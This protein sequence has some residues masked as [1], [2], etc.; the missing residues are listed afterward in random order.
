MYPKLACAP[1]TT[2]SRLRKLLTAIESY[3]YASLIYAL[4]CQLILYLL[5]YSLYFDDLSFV[6]SQL[7]FLLVTCTWHQ[8]SGALISALLSPTL[9]PFSLRFFWQWWWFTGLTGVETITLTFPCGNDLWYRAAVSPTLRLPRRL[10]FCQT[11]HC[12]P[13]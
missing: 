1:C 7:P 13:T 9:H 11:R 8:P 3:I 4:L 2:K 10:L 5:L 6:Y 12:T